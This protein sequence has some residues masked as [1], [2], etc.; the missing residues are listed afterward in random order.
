M[1]GYCVKI[2]LYLYLTYSFYVRAGHS[3]GRGG[4]CFSLGNRKP[5]L[6]G[7]ISIGSPH[8]ENRFLLPSLLSLSLHAG[9]TRISLSSGRGWLW[10][11]ENTVV[12]GKIVS[13][14]T[15][16]AAD[17]VGGAYVNSS[18]SPFCVFYYLCCL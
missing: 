2:I 3:L 11:G 16:K 7:W 6:S 13:A 12:I 17:G 5:G 8:R 14:L 1:Y 15:G 9:N 18:V 4:V 10:V